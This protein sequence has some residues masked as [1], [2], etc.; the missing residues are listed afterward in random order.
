MSDN[1]RTKP[2]TETL[3]VHEDELSPF[4]DDDDDDGFDEAWT[5]GDETHR[6]TFSTGNVVKIELGY[7]LRWLREDEGKP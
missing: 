6:A 2:R 3:D 7:V 4:A 1:E 5:F